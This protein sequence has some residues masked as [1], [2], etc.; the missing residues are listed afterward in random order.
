MIFTR[1]DIVSLFVSDVICVVDAQRSFVGII[2]I[3]ILTRIGLAIIVIA[4]GLL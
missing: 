1:I 4:R 2:F 3:P